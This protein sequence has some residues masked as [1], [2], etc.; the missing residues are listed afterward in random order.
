MRFIIFLLLIS[1]YVYAAQITFK[2]TYPIVYGK[3]VSDGVMEFPLLG[4]QYFHY[5][6]NSIKNPQ[7]N[8]AGTLQAETAGYYIDFANN[9]YTFSRK[10]FVVGPAS[11]DAKQSYNIDR[12]EGGLSKKFGFNYLAIRIGAGIRVLQVGI[13]NRVGGRYGFV[14]DDRERF[15]LYNLKAVIHLFD[16]SSF[17]IRFDASTGVG[18]KA[19]TYS[20]SGQF[21][22]RLQSGFLKGFVLGI[23]IIY[24]RIKLETQKNKAD[25]QI[26]S[27]YLS[28]SMPLGNV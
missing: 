26:V 14:E 21:G 6:A 28:I 20:F 8:V 17:P 3:V 5:E 11:L 4:V 19:K 25:V 1:T 15:Q 7:I 10:P 13:I 18:G 16:K 9:E 2:F 22:Y 12:L 24:D 23:G 27:P